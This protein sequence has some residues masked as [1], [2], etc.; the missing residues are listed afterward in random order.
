MYSS[1]FTNMVDNIQK[2][3]AQLWQRDR[4]KLETFSIN[5][6][7]YSQNHAQNCIF[8]PPY[9]RIRQNVSGLFENFNA[10][11]LCSRLSSRECQFYS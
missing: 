7:R 4:V 2:Q 10:K 3:V 5:F 8:G 6:Q 11:K 9:V 1:L